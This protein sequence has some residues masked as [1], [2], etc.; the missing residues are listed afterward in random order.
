MNE[1]VAAAD[2]AVRH[3]L[4]AAVGIRHETPGFADEH[5]ARC[6]VPGLDAA[7][8]IAITPA[9]GDKAHVERRRAEPAH[10]T[11]IAH[12]VSE[13]ALEARVSRRPVQ[14]RNPACN[15]CI[16]E[17]AARCDPQPRVVEISALAALGDVE[18]VRRG[19]VDEPGDKLAFAF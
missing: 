18:I 16:G 14:R 3:H 5:D 12:D 15:Q 2:R 4:R 9:R 6:H 10:I 8:P 13:F 19:I 17:V 7:L 11:C 1:F